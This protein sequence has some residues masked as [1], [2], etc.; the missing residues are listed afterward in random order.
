MG[1][2]QQV[3]ARLLQT[4]G[5]QCMA[6]AGTQDVKVESKGAGGPGT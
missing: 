3:S 4:A 5:G 6:A 2:L 1:E